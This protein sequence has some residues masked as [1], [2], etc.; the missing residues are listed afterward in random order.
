MQKRAHRH[1][2]RSAVVPARYQDITIRANALPRSDAATFRAAFHAELAAWHA[3]A[4]SGI[5]AVAWVEVPIDMLDVAAPALVEAG[6]VVHHG[7]GREVVFVHA[8]ATSLVPAFGTHYVR[9][10]CVVL[11]ADGTDVLVVRERGNADAIGSPVWKLVTGNVEPTEPLAVAAVREVREETGI[12]AT[13]E[14]MLGVSTRSPARFGRG[15]LC[16]AYLLRAAFG[17]APPRA[18]PRELLDARWI[19]VVDVAHVASRAAAF[20]TRAGTRMSP[21]VRLVDRVVPDF[22]GRPDAMHI[23]GP[24]NI[25]Y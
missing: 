17:A 23:H 10:E 25:E 7:A 1:R 13:P 20:W 22:C 18:D 6:Y 24:E 3:T 11:S 12:E 2:R 9:V 8:T 4:P 14:R 15:E 16:V 5:A 21:A 19:A